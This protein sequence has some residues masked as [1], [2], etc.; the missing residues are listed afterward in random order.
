LAL[1]P[2]LLAIG[3]DRGTLLRRVEKQMQV[4]QVSL[5]ELQQ[6]HDALMHRPRRRCYSLMRF[7]QP[8]TPPGET[9]RLA[10]PFRRFLRMH[11]DKRED[12]D[13]AFQDLGA[14]G[15]HHIVRSREA[16]YDHGLPHSLA[17][18]VF[19]QPEEWKEERLELFVRH[20]CELTPPLDSGQVRLLVEELK[21]AAVKAGIRHGENNVML[22][23]PGSRPEEMS[24]T[25]LALPPGTLD[26]IPLRLLN[27]DYPTTQ[28]P[29]RATAR[30]D[31]EQNL[32]E[33]AECF[34][35]E[36]E[37][38]EQRLVAE[39]DARLVKTQQ[40]WNDLAREIQDGVRGVETCQG[41]VELFDQ[42]L[43][44][45]RQTWQEFVGHILKLNDELIAAKLRALAELEQ[46]QLQWREALD[47]VDQGNEDI[48][49]RS[50][51][52]STAHRG[53]RRTSSC[54]PACGRAPGALS[55]TSPA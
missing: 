3:G 37:A 20:D 2:Q 31:M 9:P 38:L 44:D 54:C 25:V 5:H 22:L 36:I 34:E 14:G 26:Q 12:F 10:G 30:A 4:A 13:Y 19:Q 52:T 40:L 23:E 51:F 27:T 1:R 17:D 6:Q 18:T 53:H 32:T 24:L 42:M 35:V 45:Y 55:S 11:W 43:A 41:R 15:G 33:Q 46:A 48:N 49:D 39:A 8:P 50:A 28:A 29:T 21:Q 7:R 47:R 16:G